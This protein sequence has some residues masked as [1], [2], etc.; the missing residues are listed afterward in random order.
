[1]NMKFIILIPLTYLFVM[2]N[3]LDVIVDEYVTNDTCKCEYCI[4]AECLL[5]G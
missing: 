3:L 5:C 4:I 2:F 1:M